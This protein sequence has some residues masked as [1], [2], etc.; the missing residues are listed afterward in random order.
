MR[1]FKRVNPPDF[2]KQNWEKW[3][4]EWEIRK[5]AK[6][7]AKFTWRMFENQPVNQR[8]IPLLKEQTNDHCSFCDNFPVSPPSIDTIEHFRPKADFPKLA[9][10]WENLYYCCNYCQQKGDEFHD[11]LLQPDHFDYRFDRYFTWDYENGLL[12]VNVAATSEDQKRAEITI[13]IYRL[14]DGH[15][16]FRRLS[17]RRRRLDPESDLGQFAYRNFVE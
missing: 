1:H 7:S 17:S 14:N 9:Y 3:G 13:K 2:L 11:L 6:T 5:T 10:Q 8:L 12:L 15:P 16:T 4:V